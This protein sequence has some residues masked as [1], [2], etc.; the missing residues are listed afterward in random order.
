MLP[1]Q[2][3]SEL[4]PKIMVQLGPK[5][6]GEFGVNA[7]QFR[8]LRDIGNG[9]ISVG[10]LSTKFNSKTSAMSR[11][12][13]RLEEKGWVQ[14]KQDPVDR[15]VFWL[16]LTNEGRSFME[17]LTLNREKVFSMMFAQIDEQEQHNIVDGLKLLLSAIPQ[18]GEF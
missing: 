13:R 11:F 18:E 16:E 5:I 10:E 8:A 3:F 14:K 9:P 15:R 6:Y 1:Y 2:E 7:Q 12:L 4:L 17:Q